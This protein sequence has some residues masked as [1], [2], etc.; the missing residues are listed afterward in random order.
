MHLMLAKSI[1]I[2]PTQMGNI[3]SASPLAMSYR[4]LCAKCSVLHCQLRTLNPKQSLNP[5]C[6]MHCGMHSCEE[7]KEGTCQIYARDMHREV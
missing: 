1:D 4:M 2:T 6:T 5:Q 3:T 7:E